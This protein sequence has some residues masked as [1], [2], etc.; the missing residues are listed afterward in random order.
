[1]LLYSNGC[2]MMPTDRVI[3][4]SCDL[5]EFACD[6]WRFATLCSAAF[7]C[8]VS[9]CTAR[10]LVCLLRE[11]ARPKT[12]VTANATAVF[13]RDHERRIC[14]GP[15]ARI[16]CS[17]ETILKVNVV[18]VRTASKCARCDMTSQTPPLPLLFNFAFP[19]P[20]NTT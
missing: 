2:A 10:Y 19:L 13:G 4:L 17:F 18:P 16:V 14:W 11:T 3:C 9:A 7:Y 5:G 1:M 8:G 15:S 12:P 20:P 6:L